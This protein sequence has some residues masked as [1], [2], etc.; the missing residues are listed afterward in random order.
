VRGA[1]DVLR[2]P[3]DLT[4]TSVAGRTPT[5]LARGVGLT[6]AVLA[7]AVG[8]HCLAGGH[9]PGPAVLGAIAALVLV[10]GVLGARTAAGASAR[11]VAV[12]A[13]VGLAVALQPVLA[14]FASPALGT[15]LADTHAE[16]RPGAGV[17]HD[18]APAVPGAADGP[19]GGTAGRASDGAADAAPATIDLGALRDAGVDLG[20]VRAAGTDL[21]ALVAAGLDA[22]T[23]EAVGL[24]PSDPHAPHTVASLVAA[25]DR[26]AAATPAG[27]DGDVGGYDEAPADGAP[28]PGVVADP[29]TDLAGVTQAA[30]GGI[31]AGEPFD[32]AADPPGDDAPASGTT[33]DP[34]V[35]GTA[36]GGDGRRQAALVV[37]VLATG[38]LALAVLHV[39]TGRRRAVRWSPASA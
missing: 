10:A 34:G 16:H 6:A 4:T 19:V 5:V 35:T 38:L 26:A 39:P 32:D 15:A 37:T 11:A 2:V 17:A 14:M 31:L 8:G 9:V 27:A 13:A 3:A 22:A 12:L 25:A 29:P 20:A 1:G 7:G 18:D 33:L 36:L 28:V 23:L 30:P 24:D 21:D